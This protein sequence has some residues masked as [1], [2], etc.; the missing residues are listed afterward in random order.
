[1]KN[2]SPINSYVADAELRTKFD[3][4]RVKA[5][6][7]GMDARDEWE[8]IRK[9]LDALAQAAGR[10]VQAHADDVRTRIERLEK[11]LLG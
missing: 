10:A 8:S 5:H 1:M 9:D 7:A 3:A 2:N 6:I 11:K 4:L